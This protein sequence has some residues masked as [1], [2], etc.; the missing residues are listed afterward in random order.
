[1]TD[2]PWPPRQVRARPC[3]L[4]A[5]EGPVDDDRL[6]EFGT[7]VITSITVL[8]KGTGYYGG[9]ASP[10]KLAFDPANDGMCNDFS[11]VPLL[12]SS[13]LVMTSTEPGMAAPL[14][15]FHLQLGLDAKKSPVKRPIMLEK[16][17]LTG[18]WLL[19]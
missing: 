12:E 10:I 14:V 17:L 7:G 1:M 4:S 8:S 18:A 6:E 5:C 16:N 13:E 11:I 15:G 9:L 3:A 19:R 2:P